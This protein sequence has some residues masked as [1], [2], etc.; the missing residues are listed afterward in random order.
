MTAYPKPTPATRFMVFFISSAMDMVSGVILFAVPIRAALMGASYSMVGALGLSWSLGYAATTFLISRF[1]TPA[2]SVAL[3]VAAC[4]IQGLAHIG[5][6]FTTSPEGMIPFLVVCGCMH[7]VFFVPYQVFFKAVDSGTPHPLSASVGIYTFAWSLGMAFGPLWSG[8]LL[9]GTNDNF[10]RGW[11]W[12]LFFTVLSCAAVAA[13]IGMLRKYVSTDTDVAI[14]EYESDAPDFA[15]W[16]WGI[17]VCGSLAFALVRGLFPAGAVRMAISENIQGGVIFVMGFVQALSALLLIR[18]NKWMYR[19]VPLGIA[20]LL[21]AGGML[22]F[23]GAFSGWI[24]QYLIEG[25]FFAGAALFGIYSGSFFFYSVFHSLAHPRR[26]GF[27]VAV[28][29][30][31]LAIGSILGSSL[32]GILADSMGIG[33]PFKMA[34]C[35]IAAFTIILVGAHRKNS[36]K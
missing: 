15:K 34:A 12:C 20:G 19:P 24:S 22:L 6:A 33:F 5:L 35:I 4:V 28:N 18:V 13:I 25:A 8:F 7:T 16:G 14:D 11:K 27:N 30:G 17:A 10:A 32:G 21:G 3:C 2:R 23:L 36:W 29:E 1:V 9:G 31:M 26:S